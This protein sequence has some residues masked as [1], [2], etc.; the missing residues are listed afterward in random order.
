MIVTLVGLF[1]FEFKNCHLLIILAEGDEIMNDLIREFFS[2]I[3][4]LINNDIS[5]EII[6]LLIL[7]VLVVLFIFVFGLAFDWYY[8]SKYKIR[9]CNYR[10]L[11]SELGGGEE[12]YVNY[13]KWQ[14]QKKKII[15]KYLKEQLNIKR[16]YSRHTMKKKYYRKSKIPF[17]MEM[18]GVAS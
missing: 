8:K 18:Y 3:I 12:Y 15:N 16:T 13:W 17:R 6:L 5:R 9:K 7:I 14:R 2:T 1:L 4:I 10:K 11:S